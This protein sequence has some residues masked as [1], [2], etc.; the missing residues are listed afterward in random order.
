MLTLCTNS[1]SRLLFHCRRGG[2]I[3][4]GLL[5]IKHHNPYPY[6][7]MN[8]HKKAFSTKHI[9]N[10]NWQYL[11]SSDASFC[12]RYRQTKWQL[13]RRFIYFYYC[14]SDRYRQ[15]KWQLIRRFIYFYFVKLLVFFTMCYRFTSTCFD[16]IYWHHTCT[17]K[18]VLRGHD[19]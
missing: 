19:L 14:F 11:L 15:T 17:V 10:L 8:L 13:I 9:L 3:R 12:D 4:E 6:I 5:Y 18:P 2:V 1:I 16:F 7:E